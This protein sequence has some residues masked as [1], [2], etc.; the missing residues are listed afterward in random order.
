MRKNEKIYEMLKPPGPTFNNETKWAELLKRLGPAASILDIGSKDRRIAPG[1]INTDLF[2]F[3]NVD[4]ISDA[5][6]LPFKEGA[7]DAVFIDAVLECTKDPN[8]IVAEIYRVLK[9]GGYVHCQ[10]PFMQGY[11]SDPK[12]YYRWTIDGLREMFRRFRHEDSGVCC[13]PSSAVAWILREY[14]AVFWNNDT[15]Y[16]AVKFVFG[17]LLFPIKYLDIIISKKRHAHII[18]SAFYYIGRK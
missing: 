8:K 5:H 6:S 17:W 3:E 16:R 1:V 12:D 15:M 18:S 10:T 9:K 13:G 4:V 11:V 7:F 14:F 2:I